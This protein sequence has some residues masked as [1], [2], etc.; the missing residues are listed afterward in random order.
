MSD[1]V[2]GRPH[3]LTAA[4]NSR[5]VAYGSF[6]VEVQLGTFSETAAV[7]KGS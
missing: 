5:Q 2:V 7:I 4:N 6:T 1:V 3:V